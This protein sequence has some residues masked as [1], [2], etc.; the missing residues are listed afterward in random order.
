MK[1]KQYQVDAFA[2]RAFSGNPAAVCLLDQWLDD[3]L[4]Q[5]IAEENNLSETAFLV[6]LGDGFW[7]ELKRMREIYLGTTAQFIAAQ[8]FYRRNGFTEI[9]KAEL[10]ARFPLMAV[11]S[12]FFTRKVSL[13]KFGGDGVSTPSLT[14]EEKQH[15]R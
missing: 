11:D 12:V 2:E 8:R 14:Y 1:I 13:V 10:P 3:A 6:P 9:A 15:D 4:L 5:A 7:C